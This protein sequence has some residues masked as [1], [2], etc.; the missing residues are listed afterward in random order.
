M[1]RIYPLIVLLASIA[2][3]LVAVPRED[4]REGQ[5][6]EMEPTLTGQARV[7]EAGD[8]DQEE[9]DVEYTLVT[10][11]DYGGL[12]FVGQGGSIDGEVNPTLTADPGD[13]VKITVVN[14]DAITHDLT[15]DEFGVKTA[16]LSERGSEATVIFRVEEDADYIY[17]CSIPGHR[18]AGMWGTLKVGEGGE[19]PATAQSISRNPSDIPE[20]I[21]DRGPT[22]KLLKS[23]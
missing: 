21:G 8:L 16:E 15:I 10:G 20:P 22:T 13:V 11:G 7:A 14:G 18:Q 4:A 12:V 23:S 17:Y 9:A 19:T 6:G 5:P 1:R 3:V 2:L